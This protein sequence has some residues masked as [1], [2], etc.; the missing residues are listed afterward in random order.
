MQRG[1]ANE[2]R[3]PVFSALEGIVGIGS[4]AGSLLA[5]VLLAAFGARGALAVAGAIL[6][7]VAL[8]IYSRIGRNDRIAVV[9][10]PMLQLL[11]EVPAFA[12]LPLTAFERLSSGMEPLAFEPGQA[13]MRE[14]EPGDRFVVIESGQVEVSADGR[15][16]QR[17]GR[18]AGV[19]EIALL[20]RSPRTATVTA[21]TAVTAYAIPGSCFIAAV[22][23]PAAAIVTERIAAANLT[24]GAAGSS[25]PVADG[26]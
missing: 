18:G 9:D 14:G 25:G 5:P 21:L 13:I 12:E 22:S 19:G 1:T 20:R 6:P 11:R 7:I 24:R 15:P 16:M 2:E 4:V 10:E 8:V 26:A 17:M 3:A 23:G